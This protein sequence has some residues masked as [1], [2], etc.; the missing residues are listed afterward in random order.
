MKALDEPKH[1]RPQKTPNC[2]HIL[3][4]VDS[5][6]VR[7]CLLD[8]HFPTSPL[9]T[10]VGKHEE[11]WPPATTGGQDERREIGESN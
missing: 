10:G 6:P 4:G 7:A 2:P 5:I 11:G 3:I 9:D 1:D 8:S